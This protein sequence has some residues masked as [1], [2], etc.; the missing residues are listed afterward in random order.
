MLFSGYNYRSIFEQTGLSFNL[1]LSINNVT[2]SGAFGFSG[3]NNQIQ[4]TF[5]SGRIF[6]FQ[7]RYVNSYLPQE[8]IKI[9]GDIEGINYSYYINDTPICFDGIKN[10]FKVQ[11]FFYNASG[12]ILDS[13][14]IL[15]G[16]NEPLYIFD[17]PSTFAIS[18]LY[19]GIILNN[20]N[21]LAF[22]I[23]SGQ[24]LPT[25]Q[26]SVNS[27]DNI[28]S[29]LKTGN[30]KI[31]TVN[32]VGIYNLTLNLYTNFGLI[33]KN[34]DITG[35]FQIEDVINLFTTPNNL[36][37][38]S[39]VRE[40]L[41]SNFGE[42]NYSYQ[43]VSGATVLNS[44]NN[45]PLEIRFQYYTGGTGTYVGN[46]IGSGYGYNLTGTG[47]ITNDNFGSKLF[48]FT[49]YANI[50]GYNYTGGLYTGIFPATGKAVI[51]AT[52]IFDYNIIYEGS[53]FM[54][55]MAIGTFGLPYYIQ[56]F[57]G[58]ISVPNVNP[59]TPGTG[60][61]TGFN[62]TWLTG[63]V[64][65]TG[66]IFS[67]VVTGANYLYLSNTQSGLST[68]VLSGEITQYLRTGILT[69]SPGS[70]SRIPRT[71]TGDFQIV[72]SGLPI[73]VGFSGLVF[74][75]NNLY[76]AYQNLNDLGL[77]TNGIPNASTI[78][79]NPGFL[80]NFIILPIERRG[81]VILDSGNPNGI[82]SNPIFN[83][84]AGQVNKIINYTNPNLTF[85]V[86]NFNFINDTTGRWNGFLLTGSSF[87]LTGW[88]A[89]ARYNGNPLSA[90]I[91]DIF[92]TGDNVYF[93]G[94]FD[95][96]N[97]VASP[98]YSALAKSKLGDSNPTT[99]F[100]FGSN[101][102]I[103]NLTNIENL[104][105]IFGDFN[106]FF[107]SG[108]YTNTALWA[109]PRNIDNDQTNGYYN[110][111][112]II[113]PTSG[114]RAV[115][116]PYD[117]HWLDYIGVTGY[118]QFNFNKEVLDSN[119]T[120]YDVL[121]TTGKNYI[122]GN[123]GPIGFKRRIGVAA[124]DEQENLMAYNPEIYSSSDNIN[125]AFESGNVIYVGGAID[126]F[127]GVKYDGGK[128]V[129]YGT[130]QKFAKLNNPFTI[131]RSFIPP[132]LAGNS[133]VAYDFD[134]YNNNV[135]IVGSFDSYI[136]KTGGSVS[137]SNCAIFNQSGEIL[138]GN[139]EFNDYI[140]TVYITGFTGF[141]GGNFT[142]V[143]TNSTAATSRDRFAAINLI[144]HSLL[145]ITGNF[146][147]VVNQIGAYTG[148]H[149]L[150][151]G[152]FED[153]TTT[154]VTTFVNQ[155]VVNGAGDP[156][157][158]G[159]YTRAAGGTTTFTAASSNTIYWDGFNWYLND[160]TLG[161][162]TYYNLA[163]DPDAASLSANW[164]VYNGNYP[165]PTFTLSNSS[166][167]LV[168]GAITVNGLAFLDTR[169]TPDENIILVQ[170]RTSSQSASNN[171]QG[172]TRF[173]S[174]NATGFY[175]YGMLSQDIDINN[176]NL[177]ALGDTTYFNS[178]I[179][180]DVTGGIQT[181]FRPKIENPFS[182]QATIYSALASGNK[183]IIGGDFVK[184]DNT[185][186]SRIA[187]LN[188]GSGLLD[189]DY[190]GYQLDNTVFSSL[191]Y[192]NNIISVGQFNDFSGDKRG[193]RFLYHS[194]GTTDI[195]NSLKFNDTI[196]KIK[197]YSGNLYV[198]GG[199][200][201]PASIEPLNTSQQF[202]MIAL[203]NASTGFFI[204]DIPNRKLPLVNQAILSFSTG[205]S[206]IYIGG[207]FTQVNNQPRTGVALI[208][209]AGDVLDWRP[210]IF[211]GDQ[212]VSAIAVSGNAIYL[213]GNFNII[214]GLSIP[215]LAKVR[216]DTNASDASDIL[217]DFLP[218]IAQGTNINAFYL[219]DN[220]LFM[221]GDFDQINNQALRGFV[222]LNPSAGTTIN[223]SILFTDPNAIVNK[224]IK[225]GDVFLIGGDF[226]YNY[227]GQTLEH[228]L[229]IRSNG[230]ISNYP[231]GLF[232]DGDSQK[233]VNDIFLGKNNKIYI[234][235]DLGKNSFVNENLGGAISFD[236]NSGTNTFTW[237]KWTPYLQNENPEVILQSQIS[238]NIF[239]FNRFNFAGH[240]REGICEINNSG[241]LNLN[242]NPKIKID[243]SLNQY[244]KS[245][246][247]YNETG[248][249]IG[250]KFTKINQNN[251]YSNFALINTND[252]TATNL[253]IYP[254]DT[255]QTVYSTGAS[256]IYL[257]GN[258][259][260][261]TGANYTQNFANFIE[262][263]TGNTRIVTNNISFITNTNNQ[264]GSKNINI[265]SINYS[266]N[267]FLIGG[268]FKSTTPYL[269]ISGSGSFVSGIV[270]V[271]TILTGTGN[272][273][274][275]NDSGIYRDILTYSGV[276]YSSSY[277]F[278]YINNENNSIS[279][280]L[281]R[282][283][284]EIL[285]VNQLTHFTGTKFYLETG[286][287]IITGI[288]T[289]IRA[290]G[291]WLVTGKFTGYLTG[292]I[293]SN[294]Y[295]YEEPVQT[296]GALFGLAYPLDPISGDSF[297]SDIPFTGTIR[298]VQSYATANYTGAQPSGTYFLC[299]TSNFYVTG[300]NVTGEK[301][302]V[303]NYTGLSSGLILQTNSDGNILSTQINYTT[304]GGFEFVTGALGI[305]SPF[306]PVVYATGIFMYPT[307]DIL[308]T[309]YL[310][311]IPQYEK[312]FSGMFNISTGIFDQASGT[313]YY[314]GLSYNKNITGYSGFL[315]YNTGTLFNIRI[316][317]TPYQDYD[318][319]V[320]LF[321]LS[322]T[323]N[324]IFTS[325]VTGI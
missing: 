179:Q 119:F 303:G 90:S 3:E 253:N 237:N 264:T 299:E 232:S 201:F 286:S 145:P 24:L 266:N 289:L 215:S 302:I 318:Q 298:V 229:P 223:N 130:T 255:L 11:T 36:S 120:I 227:L 225:T 72:N 244:I 322:G 61:L 123:I 16:L 295:V 250:G 122:V 160:F 26:F 107:D 109:N 43:V 189:L 151:V 98:V 132:V 41:T 263:P 59:N 300:I 135:Y 274:L 177:T 104:L 207:E 317:Y 9:S 205:T 191:F 219:E 204:P 162:D 30:I 89:R 218:I 63:Y 144:T 88:D 194:S 134:F 124:Y 150:A 246:A 121:K 294:A 280:S 31:N 243:N 278:S 129:S 55:G 257:G 85:V 211:Q 13:S 206:G 319:L 131:D 82:L 57:T 301:I 56:Y 40:V 18:K 155:I 169:N 270:Y 248:I 50:T 320:G 323:G 292:S 296:T 273:T 4:F 32:Q 222:Q 166:P 249:I 117:A 203:N 186:S 251:N 7:N 324:T 44:Y 126:N 161:Y 45:L 265:N 73:N 49:G 308:T 245:S 47:I 306:G 68:G 95:E 180:L 87:Q 190:T 101:K 10:N 291:L 185:G 35:L 310:T 283:I 152:E 139:Y 304:S 200:I 214:N 110:S 279:S 198:V 136:P 64:S 210:R 195:N 182:N 187:M 267:K 233:K 141:F 288:E 170:N 21:Q 70:F 39:G 234:C 15:K 297:T 307:G 216:A 314:S 102:T 208:N 112:L 140:K 8:N 231:T 247:R 146:D 138:T 260:K 80:S 165:V 262:I 192:N 230:V 149:I 196:Y 148:D 14:L 236:F 325:L 239:I 175:L 37:I 62:T 65:G 228:F 226:E 164:D 111:L 235:G 71:V 20:T 158:D 76:A 154:A 321:T 168:Y 183:V 242:F 305:T 137:R 275:T 293:F 261:F 92:L 48:D 315:I 115:A 312:D 224:I 84:S 316:D 128:D 156:T 19:T 52:G 221:G 199:N 127:G 193:K 34:F 103:T 67:G 157:S 143:T 256:N 142:Q 29:G 188:S 25:G 281:N 269:L 5:Q 133:N 153:V 94:Y 6:D 181:G 108:N 272:L 174:N 202:G 171:F 309:G 213:G 252:S 97:L 238:N 184:I 178:I 77:A 91:N 268:N 254:S 311:G 176:I 27:V 220:S 54:T 66:F 276:N 209:Y 75:K 277:A 173:T 313:T 12:C 159:T 83:I 118:N 163:G 86:G 81:L 17:F 259:I 114:D 285:N 271:N 1:N 197:E 51:T 23:F 290:T 240:L 167:Q 79:Q 2:G 22:K 282:N 42:L 241:R 116:D 69:F 172:F 258:F 53:G 93:G 58:G 287:G 38:I 212:V 96:V 147:G 100:D 105:Y 99:Q 217:I 106:N 74:N 284:N 28:V 60:A 113:N 78:S 46:I 33:S 125:F